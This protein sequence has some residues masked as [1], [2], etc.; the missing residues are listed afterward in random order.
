MADKGAFVLAFFLALDEGGGCGVGAVGYFISGYC[1]LVVP[2][3][4]ETTAGSLPIIYFEDAI[5]ELRVCVNRSKE[6][7]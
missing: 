7:V 2:A 6:D 5:E 4:Y 3:L 1:E